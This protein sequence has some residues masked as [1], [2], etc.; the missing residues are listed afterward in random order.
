[1]TNYA[2]SGYVFTSLYTKS[3]RPSR[4]THATKWTSDGLEYA[5]EEKTKQDM[6]DW[7][8]LGNP[9][10]TTKFDFVPGKDYTFDELPDDHGGASS[11]REDAL[12]HFRSKEEGGY[13]WPGKAEDATYRAVIIPADE[14]VEKF[15]HL[16]GKPSLQKH[17]EKYGLDYPSI[18]NEGNNRR[19]AMAQLK[20]PMPHLEVI[21]T[22]QN[23][24]GRH[25]K[26]A[27]EGDDPFSKMFTD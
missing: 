15:G 1:M 23:P 22:K 6:R 8:S 20:R 2:K 27:D 14:L 17:I 24:E 10:Y 25:G 5:G 16:K 26:W 4:F 3:G 12:H 21:P 18:G 11:L 19:T 7:E 9:P 13:G